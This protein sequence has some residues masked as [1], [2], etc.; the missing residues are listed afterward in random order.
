M[1][2]TRSIHRHRRTRTR[3]ITEQDYQYLLECSCHKLGRKRPHLSCEC[4][5]LDAAAD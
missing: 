1:P 3:V 4:R 5:D 2:G